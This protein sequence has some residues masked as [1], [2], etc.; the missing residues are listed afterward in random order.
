VPNVVGR[1]DHSAP[2]PQPVL[3]A[4]TAAGT[5]TAIVG[6]LLTVA[7]VAHWITPDDSAILGPALSTA[8]T[9]VVGAGSAIVAA[10][11]A[12]QQVTPLVSPRNADGIELV[13]ITGLASGPA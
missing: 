3:G 8:I 1:A 7:V 13:P 10:L 5:L 11:K 6:L 2:R 9:A 12:R 4:A